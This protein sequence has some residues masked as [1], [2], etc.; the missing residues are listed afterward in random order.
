MSQFNN[1]R[2][3][4]NMKH[5]NDNKEGMW[6]NG[7]KE[8]TGHNGN[9]EGT[10][11]N[12]NKEGTGFNKNREETRFNRNG[13]ENRNGFN[14][15]KTHNQNYNNTKYSNSNNSNSNNSN[16]NY[17]NSNSNNSNYNNS[18]Y[19][20]SSYNNQKNSNESDT[21]TN[22]IS[23]HESNIKNYLLNYLYDKI[24]VAEHKYT[25]IKNISDIYDL[26]SKK[27]YLSANS[28]GI[29]S[30]LVFLKKDGEYFSYLI[31]RRSIS[32]NR[33]TLNRS[34]VRITEI[35]LSV[36]LKLYD[37]TILDGIIIDSDSN[38]I[39]N[40]N[41]ISGSTNSSK[42]NFMITDIFVLGGKSLITMDYKKKM[43][44]TMFM[45]EKLISNTDKSNNIELHLSRPYEL[46]EI[47]SLFGEYI[48]PNIKKFNIKGITFYPQYSGTKIIYIFDKQDD[49]YK[50][51]L[52]EGNIDINMIGEENDSNIESFDYSDK[53][54]IFKF[55]LINPECIDDIVLN[56][57]M[58]K[59]LIPDVYKLFG[60]FVNN[61]GE[62]PIYIKKRIG[63]AYIPTYTLSIKC[64]L[65][66]LNRESIVM[67]CLFN[68]NK[69][70]WIPID[71]ATVQQIDIVNEEKR[72]KITEQVIE[73]EDNEYVKPDE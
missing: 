11:H 34:Q 53:K 65:Y 25:I 46:N 59:T 14:G 62:K 33:Q 3:S 40:N 60:I 7:N 24:E 28:C 5:N 50:S 8:G 20:N 52:F 12:G 45:L 27:Y 36:D 21:Q 49:K 6:R 38:I 70:K 1:S 63:V 31:D 15:L 69:N 39:G 64:K 30:I 10:G 16:S 71:E 42:I 61:Q 32:Y 19:N 57:E 68:T 73:I 18:N 72:L 37:G 43:Y 67:S 66:F 17:N 13:N 26:K 23:Q 58:T 2:F 56:F 55:E 54:R 48:S 51:D 35:K 9:K 44:T 41:L 4:S 29:N 22:S 47:K